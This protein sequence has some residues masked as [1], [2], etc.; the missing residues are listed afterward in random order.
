MIDVHLHLQDPR[1]E[2]VVDAFDDQLG[3][4]GIDAWVVNGTGPG[5]WEDVARI[6]REHPAVIP[7]YGVHPWK[8]NELDPDW[9]GPLRRRLEDDPGAG[10]GEIGLDR[11]IRDHDIERQ[12]EILLA[13]LNLAGEFDRPVTIHCLQ[14]WGHLDE[15][16]GSSK[17][18]RPFLLHSYGGP[19]EFVP[20]MLDRGAYFSISGYFFRKNKTEKLAVFR[21][22]PEDRVLVETDAPDMRPPPELM[23]HPVPG[24]TEEG[25]A[26]NH[27]ANLLAIH[28]AYAAF[29]NRDPEEVAATLEENFENWFGRSLRPDR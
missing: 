3:G 13:Q 12:K 1:L 15:V 28:R 24:D 19:S 27:P 8:V 2:S 11:W 26:A 7:C 29:R 6:A 25:E 18:D 23:E 21:E 9:E 5:D 16:L 10:V 17:L 20:R 22:I 4:L 14:A